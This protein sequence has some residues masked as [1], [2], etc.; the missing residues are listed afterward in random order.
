MTQTLERTKGKLVAID[1]TEISANG[2]TDSDIDLEEAPIVRITRPVPVGREQAIKSS[3]QSRCPRCGGA[4]MVELE[5]DVPLGQ[6]HFYYLSCFCC[7]RQFNHDVIP[8]VRNPQDLTPEETKREANP[9]G[10]SRW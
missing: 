10:Y 9:G 2:L 4:L 8:L 3:K 1:I 7:S 6:P 5:T